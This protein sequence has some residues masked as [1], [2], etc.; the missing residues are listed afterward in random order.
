[1]NG[2]A[3]PVLA[4][5]AVLASLACRES[6]A[7]IMWEIDETQSS[8]TLAIPDF[9]LTVGSLSANVRIRDQSGGTGNTGPWSIGNKAFIDGTIDTVYAEEAQFI[10]FLGASLGDIVGLNSGS[11]RP[12]PAAFNPANTNT[13]NP[14]GQYSNT[15]TAAAVFGAK[16]RLFALGG[17]VNADA[18]FLSFSDVNYDLFSA[19]IPLTGIGDSTF[20]ANTLSFG[21]A[22]ADIN[23]D[24][25]SAGLAGQVIPDTLDSVSNLIQTNT[26]PLASIS[27]LGGLMRKLTI[28]ISI[29]LAID[30]N[31]TIINGTA[32]GQ[33]VA[34]AVV[35]E[36]STWAMAISS[37]AVYSLHWLRRRR[38]G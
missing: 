15:T 31:G 19:V 18:A 30:L 9:N 37:I 13:A 22:E 4:A 27:N 17:L 21:I 3:I 29:P 16:V 28:P 33:I 12:N 6:R 38:R 2:K 1:M 14:N 26:A 35:P 20:A 23:A 36:P 10:Q 32:T 11:Y 24:G 34:T 8:L 7:G 5:L 25:V